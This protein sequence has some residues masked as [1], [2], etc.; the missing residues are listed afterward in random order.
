MVSPLEDTKRLID[1]VG[2]G[3]ARHLLMTGQI[4]DA[5]EAFSIGL[6]D[7]VWPADQLW[8]ET[9][10]YTAVLSGLSQFSIRAAK[11]VIGQI[12][13]GE[14]VETELSCRLFADGF[15]GEDL[16]EG[17]KAFLAKRKPRF[18]FS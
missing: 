14:S 6:V 2:L 9:N 10:A 15:A 7:R 16:A 5:G 1:T 11:A 18:T 12:L 8:D 13:A 3:A 4:V 17:A